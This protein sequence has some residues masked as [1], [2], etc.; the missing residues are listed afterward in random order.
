MSI[1]VIA[2][3][4]TE[5][6]IYITPDYI[7]VDNIEVSK[8]EIFFCGHIIVNSFYGKYAGYSY[9]VEDDRLYLRLYC[10]NKEQVKNKETIEIYIKDEKNSDIDEIY[11][12][13][14]IDKLI[15]R[16]NG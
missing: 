10:N 4:S 16:K 11:L 3:S 8:G 12:D 6:K 9:F 15:W 14:S 2:F 7:Y 5:K 13:G 1:I